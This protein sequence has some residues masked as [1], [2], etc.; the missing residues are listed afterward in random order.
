MSFKKIVLGCDHA[1]VEY[2][3]R[4]IEFINA[5]GFETL[6][7][8]TFTTESCD[9]PII[10]KDVAKKVASHEFDAGILICGTGIGMSITAN[11]VKGIRASLC[12]D[13]FSAQ[14]TRAHNNSNILC[15]GARVIDIDLALEIVDIWLSTEFEGGR[16]QRRIDMIE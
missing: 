9:Y 13:K 11:K 15:M 12:S 2:K 14:A 5:K 7:V 3:N 4:I 8:G 1:G 6:D 10:A 16:H